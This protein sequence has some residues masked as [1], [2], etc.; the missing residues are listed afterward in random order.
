MRDLIIKSN[1]TTP[2]RIGFFSSQWVEHSASQSLGR[3]T[4][5]TLVVKEGETWFRVAVHRAV[6]MPL[7]TFLREIEKDVNRDDPTV[8]LPDVP[9]EL[10]EALIRLVYKG[11]APLSEVVTVESLLLLMRM[12]GLAMPAERMIVTRE[13]VE[14]EVEIIGFKNLYGL[15][16]FETKAGM[17]GKG[18]SAYN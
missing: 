6:I 10:L 4:D 2:D 11:F 3:L 15:E 12:L 7:C 5:M 1:I 13:K 17:H 18:I 14:E 16:I 9:L 8:I